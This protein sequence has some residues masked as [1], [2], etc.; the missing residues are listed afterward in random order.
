MSDI[1]DK[2]GKKIEVGDSVYTPFRGGRH[3]GEVLN[4]FKQNRNYRMNLI[5]VFES[6]WQ[7]EQIVRNEEEAQKAQ[8]ITPKHPPKVLFHDQNDKL[9]SH[10]PGTLEKTS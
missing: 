4:P 3:E 8:G 2:H 1:T 10:N 9:V 6:P 5:G 7:V